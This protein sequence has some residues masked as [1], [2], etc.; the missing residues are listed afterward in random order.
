M[1]FRLTPHERGF[2]PLFTRAAENIAAAADLLAA[3]ECLAR[4]P[5]VERILTSGGRAGAYEGRRT[6]RD[7]AGRGSLEIMAGA[8]VTLENVAALVQ[9]TGVQAVHIGSA[10]RDPQEP[11]APVSAERVRRFK[12]ILR[13]LE[14]RHP[15]LPHK[16]DQSK[17]T[18]R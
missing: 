5:R 15:A 9:E 7:L 11:A 14:P 12:E 2:Y 17:T 1:A 3:M 10:A 6:L 16:R 13:A 8:G 18:P 4:V